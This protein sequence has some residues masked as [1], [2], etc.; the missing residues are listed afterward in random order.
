MTDDTTPP[1]A[2]P[3]VPDYEAL[4]KHLGAAG[5]LTVLVGY[6]TESDRGDVY[7]R[8]YLTPDLSAYVDILTDDIVSTLRLPT[9]QYPLG[10]TVVWIKR[11]AQLRY[12]HTST[13]SRQIQAGF[14][15]GEIAS[16]YLPQSS[17][18]ALSAAAGP[19]GGIKP[20]RVTPNCMTNNCVGTFAIEATVRR[21]DPDQ[22]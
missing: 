16:A 15:H 4:R 6:P 2:G 12:T 21:L 8:L 20:D 14:L 18:F 11:D 10:E 19:G 7:R 3:G 13:I 9:T 5:G 17:S 1:A 22:P